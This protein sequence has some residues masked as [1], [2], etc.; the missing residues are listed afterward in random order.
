M[1]AEIGYLGERT[2]CYSSHRSSEEGF[3][4]D[5]LNEGII[6]Q[7]LAKSKEL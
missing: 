2:P 7:V 5:T 3:L 6:L 4:P 1:L